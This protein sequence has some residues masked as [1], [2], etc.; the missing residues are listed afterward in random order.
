MR[1]FWESFFPSEQSDTKKSFK[2]S[3]EILWPLYTDF[4]NELLSRGEGYEGMI[5]REVAEAFGESAEKG[6]RLRDK[7]SENR[8][9]V[10]IG[11]NALNPCEKRL[12]DELKTMGVA[13]FYWDS[14]NSFVKDPANRASHFIRDNIRQFPSSLEIKEYPEEHPVFEL[15][16]VPSAVGQTRAVREILEESGGDIDTAVI[17]PDPDLL[18]PLLNSLPAKVESVNVTMGYPLKSA[19]I[20]SLAESIIDLQKGRTYYRRVLPVLRHNYIKILSPQ[21]S[22]DLISRIV[23]ENLVYVPEEEFVKDPLLSLIFKKNIEDISDYL[24]S[25][26]EAVNSCGKVTPMERE[27]NFAM[28]SL[29][30][31]LKDSRIVMSVETYGRILRKMVCSTN[32][33]LNGEPLSGLQVMG[34]LESRVLNFENVIICSMNEGL[35]PKT[36]SMNSFIPLNLRRGFGLPTY[37]HWDALAAYTFYRLISGTKRVFMIYDS[38]SEGLKSGEVSRFVQQLKYHYGVK[39][40]EKPVVYNLPSIDK[41]RV[42]VQ[43]TCQV[44]EDTRKFIYNPDGKLSASSLNDYIECPFR[45]FLKYIKGVTEEKEVA[46]G[47]EADTFGSVFHKAAEMLYSDFKGKEVSRGML[48]TL[49]KEEKIVEEITERAFRS[50]TGISDIRGRNYIVFTMIVR[51][52]RQLL[53]Y[54]SQRTPFVYYDSEKRVRTTLYLDEESF[55]ILKGFLDRIDYQ[56]DCMR[57]VDYKTGSFSLE[58]STIEAL[59]ESG[60]KSSL[61]VTFQ[62]YLYALMMDKE[63]LII[64]TYNLKSLSIGKRVEILVKREE[65][66]RFSLLIKDLVKEILN[67]DI[68]FIHI[69]QEEKC[70]YCPFNIICS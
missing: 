36:P 26:I 19:S 63:E 16:S 59:F 2:A 11:F 53:I 37:E 29:V 58:N 62:M 31:K 34:V 3:W 10:F 7:L 39:L 60:R 70:K 21:A 64:T 46:E 42:E 65:L 45:F 35:F 49:H 20:V 66:E 5:Y 43:K 15:V 67:P 25:V 23:N 38:R 12:M 51:Y 68:P 33:P 9:Y 28:L 61:S 57:I 24:I 52:L 69:P 30:E 1:S 54:D 50:V 48:L 4:R 18:V 41:K 22:S 32:I 55:V 13:D 27:F 17:L 56:G 44:M 40:I 14:G 47:I 8:E 6:K